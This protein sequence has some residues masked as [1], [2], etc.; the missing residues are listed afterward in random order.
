M[1]PPPPVV[2]APKPAKHEMYTL[3]EAVADA[4]ASPLVYIDT[5]AWFGMFRVH[6]CLYH[7]D[8]V[9]VVNV[10]CT[11]SKEMTA[12]RVDVF[13]PTRG[14]VTIYAEAKAPISTITRAQYFTFKA[15]AEPA[16]NLPPLALDMTLT[17][18]READEARY[19][20]NGPTCWG[21]IDVVYKQK[22]P[23]G[24]CRSSLASHG[25]AW[26]ERNLPF[27]T[28]PPPA[29]YDLVRELRKRAQHDGHDR[30]QIGG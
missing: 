25:P 23:T 5:G 15:E 4:L 8:R 1:N 24:Q 2:E 16:A 17:R 3:D 11:K 10:Y 13:S 30:G 12:F 28:E 14:R 19:N 22:A 26:S 7:N 6:A 20:K 21:G 18:L 9:L 27:L 29:W